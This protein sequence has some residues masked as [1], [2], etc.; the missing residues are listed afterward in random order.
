M[1]N[2]QFISP[3]LNAPVT[4]KY[5]VFAVPW[6]PTLFNGTEPIGFRWGTW[7]GLDPPKDAPLLDPFVIREEFLRLGQSEVYDFLV[8]TG[9]FHRSGFGG[10]QEWQDLIGKLM[11]T[12]PD[13]WPGLKNVSELKMREVLSL[14]MPKAKLAGTTN[15]VALEL[16][17]A[18]TLGAMVAQI[19]VEHLSGAKFRFCR[20]PYCRRPFEISDPRKIYCDHLCATRENMR[21]K[22]KRDRRRKPRSLPH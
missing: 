11:V 20:S 1:F 5:Q 22:R 21:R 6:K 7:R 19:Q 13:R 17:T 2:K 9:I 3:I 10:L 18:S 8:R 4:V 14:P 16:W 15:K 12:E